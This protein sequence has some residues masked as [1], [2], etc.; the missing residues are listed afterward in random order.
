MRNLM[1]L[2]LTMPTTN[3]D[4]VCQSTTVAALPGQGMR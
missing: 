3:L 4:S 2:A 1:T